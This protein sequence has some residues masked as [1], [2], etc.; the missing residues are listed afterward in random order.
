MNA[1]GVLLRLYPRE[2][3]EEYGEDMAQLLRDQLRDESATRVW[4]RTVLD[5]ALTAP[6]IRLE[7]HMSRGTSAPIV[8]GTATVACLVLAI[9]AGTSIGVSVVGL[10]G[11]FVFGA[12]AFISWRRAR[13]L[14][15]SRH[16]A[17]HWWKYLGVGCVA[18]AAA[19]VGAAM[20]DGELSEGSWAVWFGGL[21]FSVGLIAAGTILGINHAVHRRHGGTP[22]S[23]SW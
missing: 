17:M 6:S 4:A 11:V 1:Y 14:E 20:A 15:P 2:F 22:A 10:A 19:I 12:L 13:T 8:Y 3:R 5:V 18:L 9:V 21:L 23:G 7:A 16:A